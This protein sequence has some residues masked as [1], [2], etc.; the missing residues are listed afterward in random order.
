MGFRAMKYAVRSL[1]TRRGNHDRVLLS[2]FELCDDRTDPERD[3][4]I[5]GNIYP[6]INSLSLELGASRSSIKRAINDL[7]EDGWIREKKTR[8][9][10]KTYGN[11]N[12][13]V[14]ICYQVNINRLIRLMSM[15]VFMKKIRTKSGT[16]EYHHL[17]SLTQYSPSDWLTA[18]DEKM[19]IL[20]LYWEGPIMEADHTIWN[21]V[22]PLSTD[23]ES[24]G[25]NQDANKEPTHEEINEQANR[26][27]MNTNH[28]DNVLYITEKID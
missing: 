9:Y 25:D 4:V 19:R 22:R 27:R 26:Y 2:F 10:I 28:N 13:P 14:P 15:K 8:R 7:K 1:D 16:D 6:S 23:D 5:G 20:D 21:Q 17:M 3:S 12:G 18:P 11:V 24:Y